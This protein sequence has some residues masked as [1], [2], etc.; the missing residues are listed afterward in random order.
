LLLQD[1]I[2]LGVQGTP[3][4]FLDGQLLEPTSVEDFRG[5]IDDALT[6]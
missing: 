1:G 2:D 5:A 4:F 6:D 3:T